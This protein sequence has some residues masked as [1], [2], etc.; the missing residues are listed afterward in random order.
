MFILR[1]L[2]G[3]SGEYI[4]GLYCP[5]LALYILRDILQFKWGID[6]QDYGG[7][8][9]SEK[10][11]EKPHQNFKGTI[12]GLDSFS[13]SVKKGFRMKGRRKLQPK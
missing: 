2:N 1:N 4:G 11:P 5:V 8:I 9:K 12:S 10:T 7:I 3:F 13:E 6:I